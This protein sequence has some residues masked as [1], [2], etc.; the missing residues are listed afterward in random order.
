MVHIW[1]AR[2]AA[3]LVSA[4][5]LSGCSAETWSTWSRPGATRQDLDIERYDCIRE[6][7][8]GFPPVFRACMEAR[9]WRK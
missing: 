9:G 3:V 4:A 5:L 6:S 7:G 8:G 2:A 1:I